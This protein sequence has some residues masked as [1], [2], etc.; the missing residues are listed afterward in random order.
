MAVPTVR[1]RRLG[2]ELRRLRERQ[3][4]TADEIA[5]RLG[6][7]PSKLSRIENA[8]IKVRVSDVRLLLELYRLED[9]HM[10]EILALAETAAQQGW[11]A[12]YLD[13]L[14]GKFAT[15]VALENDASVALTY[16]TYVLPGLMQSEEYARK[17][18]ETSEAIA[19]STPREIVRRLEARM[20]RKE[21]LRKNDPLRLSAIVDESVLVRIV[22]DRGVM[23]RQMAHLSELAELPNVEFLVLPLS[24]HREPIVS[25]T[26]TLLEFGPAYDVS[27]PD[28]AYLDN[29]S[30]M[31]E[32]Q[33]DG[34]THMYR[35]TWETLR[36]FCLSGDE[37]AQLLAVLGRG[38]RMR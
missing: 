5:T 20:R 38:F 36:T 9:A 19:I 3:G 8:R 31:A 35:R 23:E 15:Y 21:L 26:F 14:P 24:V 7:S 1:Q 4:P 10:S 16:A 25:E 37:S 33:D 22:G 17:T 13:A 2:A 34:I 29:L 30:I 27:F 12:D 11:W 6:W 32:L 18:L 28:I